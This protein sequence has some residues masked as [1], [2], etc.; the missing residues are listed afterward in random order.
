MPTT[1][2]PVVPVAAT[3][4]TATVETVVRA[5]LSDLVSGINSTKN[6]RSLASSVSAAPLLLGS[7][8]QSFT[9]NVNFTQCQLFEQLEERSACAAGGSKSISATLSGTITSNTNSSSGSLRW[10]GYQSFSDCTEG[11]WVTNSNPYMSTGGSIR[12]STTGNSSRTTMTLTMGG[13]F[14]MTNAPGR[15]AGRLVCAN[16]GVILQWDE[17]TGWSNSGSLS[18]DNGLSFKY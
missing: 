6:R 15:A 8:P 9:C 14:V 11:G 13:G 16:S 2:D 12:I 1:P 10:D 4:P 17:L 18:C 5:V 7:G 3:P